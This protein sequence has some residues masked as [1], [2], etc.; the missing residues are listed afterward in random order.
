MPRA[1]QWC[2]QCRS[3]VTTRINLGVRR[4]LQPV[5]GARVKHALRTLLVIVIVFGG[6]V[7]AIWK[8]ACDAR[9]AARESDCKSHLKQLGL[10]LANYCETYGGLPAVQTRIPN[11]NVA[12]SWRVLILPFWDRGQLYEQYD[13]AVPWNHDKNEFI[14]A[15]RTNAFF[16]GCPSGRSQTLGTTNYFAVIDA[17]TAWQ[18][19]RSFSLK[20]VTD[21]LS[22]T[23]LV[24]EGAGATHNWSAPHDPTRDELVSSGVSSNHR[25]HVHALFADFGVRR[26]R[27]DIDP[28]TLRALLTV[29]GGED[30]V[31]TDWLYSPRD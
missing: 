4:Q 31:V 21:N 12:H 20:N 15:Y 22:E 30:I 25:A 10:A 18:V 26:I 5:V 8:I 19:D 9:E 28:K 14:R 16:Y 2:N 3:R 23:I 24:I 7:A 27:H 11:G 13:M 29:A 17:T 1:S 6:C